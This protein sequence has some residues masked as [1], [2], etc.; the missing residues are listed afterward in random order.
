[1]TGQILIVQAKARPI[2]VVAVTTVLSRW[3]RE[4]RYSLDQVYAAV[5]AGQVRQNGQNVMVYRPR[6]DGRI[7]IECGIETGDRF[8]RVGEVVYRE[9]PSGM[10]VTTTHIGPYE[11]L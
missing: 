7:D 4:F 3:P 2:A 8:D 1:M 5:K 9:T 11:E 10:A 6:E